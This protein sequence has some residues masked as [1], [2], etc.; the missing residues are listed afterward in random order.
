MILYSNRFSYFISSL[1][2]DVGKNI[3]IIS[4]LIR[5]VFPYSDIVRNSLINISDATVET[6]DLT[7]FDGVHYDSESTIKIGERFYSCL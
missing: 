4:A 3:K 6:N 1:R 2:N 5:N 7:V